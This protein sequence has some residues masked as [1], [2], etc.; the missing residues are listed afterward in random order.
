MKE[1]GGKHWL[2]SPPTNLAGRELNRHPLGYKSDARTA[3]PRLAKTTDNKCSRE[4]N[5]KLYVITMVIIPIA[6]VMVLYL[7]IHVLSQYNSF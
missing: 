5:S 7:D 4:G 3:Y 1:D 2:I 6:S